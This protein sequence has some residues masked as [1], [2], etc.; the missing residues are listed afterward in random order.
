MEE[1]RNDDNL[2]EEFAIPV[3]RTFEAQ[4]NRVII[5][6]DIDCFYAQVEM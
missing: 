1:L 4:H 5:H 6:I 3:S 2:D